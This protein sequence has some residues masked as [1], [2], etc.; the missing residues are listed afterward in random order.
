MTA[1]R[2][3]TN[4]QKVSAFWKPADILSRAFQVS[5]N[6]GVKSL[7][8]AL[9]VQ[10]GGDPEPCVCEFGRP[11]GT[12]ISLT[13]SSITPEHFLLF[14]ALLSSLRFSPGCS[15]SS[16]DLRASGLPGDI[17]G[18]NT[19][20]VCQPSSFL[21]SPPPRTSMGKPMLPDQMPPCP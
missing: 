9:W 21:L 7:G 3:S 1:T 16:P 10:V 6:S 4:F 19:L 8:R 18:A 5:V 12:L 20:A 15:E 17:I 11:L 13:S 14:C 2:S